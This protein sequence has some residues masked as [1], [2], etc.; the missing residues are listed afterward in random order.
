MATVSGVTLTYVAKFTAWLLA[1]MC[2]V[3]DI[4]SVRFRFCTGHAGVCG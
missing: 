3:R 1:R 4:P 2:R